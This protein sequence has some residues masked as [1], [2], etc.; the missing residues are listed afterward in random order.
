MFDLTEGGNLTVD[1]NLT[2]LEQ[3][4]RDITSMSL[5]AEL[6]R[7]HYRLGHMSF[8]KLRMLV[9]RNIIPKKILQAKVPKYGGCLV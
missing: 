5:Q 9:V 6:L 2:L 1:S 7:W 3:D 8:T 4:E